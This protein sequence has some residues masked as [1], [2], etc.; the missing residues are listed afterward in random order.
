MLAELTISNFAIIDKLHVRLGAGFNAL[1]GETGAGKSIIIDA[2]GA[3][4]GSKTGPEFVRHG[5]PSARVEGQFDLASMH[6]APLAALREMLLQGGLSD[7]DDGSDDT[8][9]ISREINASGRTVA[10][11]N[12]R[13]VNLP[14]LAQIGE[15]LVDVHGQSEHV[16]L[17][18][19][20]THIDLLDEYAGLAEARREVAALVSRLRGVQ[21][22]LRDLQRDERELARRA[23][24]LTYQVEEI[25]KAAVQPGEDEELANERSRLSNAERLSALCD[26]I[27]ALLI[28]AE[29]DDGR[30]T[31][32]GGPAPAI[33]VRDALGDASGML[34]EL[35][36]LDP[37]MEPHQPTL[38]VIYD[39]MEE[40]GR[41][42]R[43]YRE[44]VEHDPARLEELEERISLLHE[45]KRKYG[46]SIDDVIAFGQRAAEELD[47][48]THSEERVAALH[49][50]SERLAQEIGDLAARMS[51]AR[52]EVGER[53]AHAV[54]EAMKALLMGSTRFKAEITQ[55][56]AQDGV[57]LPGREG[58]WAFSEKGVDRVEFLISPNPGEPLKPLAKIASGGETSRLM[59]ALKSILSEADLTPTLVFDEVDVGVGGRSGGVV[60]EKLWGLT[61]SHQVLCITH[62]P[63]IASFAD[64]HF[65]ITKQ[66]VA[67]RTRTQ[68]EELEGEDRETEIA[69]MIGGVPISRASLENAREMLR[70][71]DKL[72]Q[73]Q[74][75]RFKVQ[76]RAKSETRK[77][78]ATI[79]GR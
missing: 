38:D 5:S 41:T 9:I 28:E 75:S 49:E 54:E 52:S 64:N 40:L 78:K 36:R 8:V 35:A 1:T 32:R 44:R 70:D 63:Q 39:S 66:V 27:Y 10:R 21:R 19:S 24:L 2:L 4:L 13:M 17:L 50:E 47:G 73:A 48:I 45:L 43:V 56:P 12:G 58:R 7:T 67:D 72:K 25:E 61:Q 14:T 31:G 60:G 42:M 57:P 37:S 51:E 59:L 74:S 26:A 65:K 69:A 6:P 79:V 68:V 33:S 55:S 3:L 29:D 18:R 20:S 71:G 53:L 30:R 34:A 23:D 76:S 62:L 11:V 77:A 46:P 16:S 15:L 22:E